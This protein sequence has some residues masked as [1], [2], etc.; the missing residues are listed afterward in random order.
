MIR[1]G[2]APR[3]SPED[4][5]SS[6]LRARQVSASIRQGVEAECLTEIARD[7]A[8]WIALLDLRSRSGEL[9]AHS[10]AGYG[11]RR[12]AIIRNAAWI[13]LYRAVGPYPQIGVFLRCTGLAGEAF[14]ALADRRRECIEPKLSAAL[15]L[16][17]EME[18]GSSHHPGMTDIAA[19]IAAPLHWDETAAGLHMAWLLRS[20]ATWWT[21]FAS[22]VN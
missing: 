17:A 12:F 20:G 8:F 19:I 1:Q 22:L 9:P 2:A 11:N 14:F 7:R 10:G 21:T 3:L 6:S 16:G 4:L 13:T 18:W 5:A 15:G